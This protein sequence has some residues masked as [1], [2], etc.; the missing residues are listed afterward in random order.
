[1]RLH[2]VDKTTQT[3]GHWC[4]FLAENE[5]RASRAASFMYPTF[6]EALFTETH[7]YYDVFG[8]LRM[9]LGVTHGWPM[10]IAI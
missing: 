9:S 10:C 8:C 2:E 7:V 5:P 1:M 4:D 3:L 6:S